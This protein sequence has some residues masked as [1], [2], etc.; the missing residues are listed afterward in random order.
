MPYIVQS[1]RNS[2]DNNQ[3]IPHGSGELNY[4][5]TKILLQYVRTRGKNY[6]TF[7]DIS[8]ALVNA[9]NE[10]YRRV[11]APYEDEKIKL[12]GDVY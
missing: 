5:I 6:Q 3:D 1:R 2:L 12:N 7:N 11:V 8:G 4:K 9:G 10:F